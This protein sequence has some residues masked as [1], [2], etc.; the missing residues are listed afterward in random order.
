MFSLKKK[1]LKNTGKWEK[2][3]WKSQRFLSVRRSGNHVSTFYV[4]VHPTGDG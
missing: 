3:Y 2:K 1:T 4:H